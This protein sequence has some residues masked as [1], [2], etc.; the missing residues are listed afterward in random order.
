MLDAARFFASHVTDLPYRRVGARLQGVCYGC[1]AIALGD[2]A[3]PNPGPDPDLSPN[4]I[5]ALTVTLTLALALALAL[6]L[7]LAR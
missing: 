1:Q 7:G 5:L 6:A 3:R 2:D 4:L